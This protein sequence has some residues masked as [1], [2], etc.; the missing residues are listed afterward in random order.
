MQQNP[1]VSDIRDAQCIVHDVGAF[2]LSLRTIAAGCDTRVICFNR[3]MM[4]G[5]IHALTAVQFA[6]RAFES[7]DTISNTLEMECLLY[8]AGSRQCSTA[9]AFGIHRGKNR[10]FVCCYPERAGVW[11]ALAPL[12][13]FTREDRDIIGPEKKAHLMT[14]FGISPEEIEAA[15][16]EARFVDLVLERV[17]LLQVTR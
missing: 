15:G 12:F 4:A 13:H 17:A 3:E 10:L 5:K 1:V 16:G 6:I 8:A 14:S 7:G 11:D 2:L 9:T